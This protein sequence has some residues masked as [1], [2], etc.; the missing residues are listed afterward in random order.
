[1]PTAEEEEEEQN[2]LELEQHQEAQQQQQNE[3]LPNTS[4]VAAKFDLLPASLPK[5]LVLP[6]TEVRAA[7]DGRGRGLFLKESGASGSE[8]TGAAAGE[9]VVSVRPALT[10]LFEPFCFTHCLGCFAD[11]HVTPGRRCGDCERFAVC[12]DCDLAYDL[13]EWHASPAAPLG[14]CARWKALPE[15]VSPPPPL[16]VPERCVRP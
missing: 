13:F 10:L 7:G 1:M 14:E 6:R 15:P 11:L 2:R 4:P 12:R 16:L 8:D 3:V 9:V 5:S